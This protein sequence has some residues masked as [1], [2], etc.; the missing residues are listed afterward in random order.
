MPTDTYESMTSNTVLAY[1]RAHKLGRF[2]P[3]APSQLEAQAALIDREIDERDIVVGARC[4][5]V[6]AET[7]QPEEVERRGEVAYV[8]EV[9]EL[10]GVGRWVGVR[11]DEPTG[12]NDG[13]V[14]GKK[15][16]DAQGNNRG[17]IVRP[18]RVEV[19]NFEVVDEFGDEDMEEI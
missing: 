15:Y 3:T 8:G 17:V 10:P 4:R 11:L 18:E 6:K 13:S 7:G 12:K 9:E 5:L 19:G 1:K 16:F 2:D 14:K